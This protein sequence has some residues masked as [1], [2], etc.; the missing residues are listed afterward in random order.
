MLAQSALE[1]GFAVEEANAE[2]LGQV[3]LFSFFYILLNVHIALAYAKTCCT[4]HGNVEYWMQTSLF[5]SSRQIPR[6]VLS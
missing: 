1:R 6:D 3:R 5:P 4:D 2:L